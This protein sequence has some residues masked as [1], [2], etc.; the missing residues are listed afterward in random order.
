MPVEHDDPE[1][2]RPDQPVDHS[3]RAAAGPEDHCLTRHLLPPH[4]LVERRREPRDVRVVA[5]EPPALAG[6]CVHRA[7][8]LRLFGQPVDHRHD[9]FLVRDRDIDSEEVVAAD[10]PDGIRERDRGA[11]PQLVLRVDALRVEGGLL[12]RPRQGVGDG[13]ADENDPLAHDRILSRSS[14]KVGY[15]T[16][17]LAASP[18]VVWPPAMRPAMA[19]V[20]ASR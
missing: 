15:E 9:P 18:M 2:A 11:I 6:E 10:L 8:R 17:T 4:E 5:H 16:E 1:K 20:S 3:A 7:G 14:K 12:H 13:V 19:N